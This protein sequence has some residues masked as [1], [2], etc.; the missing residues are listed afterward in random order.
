MHARVKYPNMDLEESNLEKLSNIPAFAKPAAVAEFLAFALV[1]DPTAVYTTIAYWV[2]QP[3]TSGYHA[4]DD[5]DIRRTETLLQK[6][7]ANDVDIVDHESEIVLGSDNAYRTSSM[8][9]GLAHVPVVESTAQS[10][11]DV[12]ASRLLKASISDLEPSASDTASS[13]KLNT[14]TYN[15]SSSL[16]SADCFA[17]I[18]G[19]NKRFSFSIKQIVEE[20][21]P[22]YVSEIV[23]HVYDICQGPTRLDVKVL[24]SHYIDPVTS[25]KANARNSETV[26]MQLWSQTHLSLPQHVFM[27]M[28]W[29][30][31]AIQAARV[32][33]QAMWSQSQSFASNSKSIF[34]ATDFKFQHYFETYYNKEVWLGLYLQFYFSL[35]GHAANPEQY[36]M[37]RTMCMQVASLIACHYGYSTPLSVE[38]NTFFVSRHH[39]LPKEFARKDNFVASGGMHQLLHTIDWDGYFPYQLLDK[40]YYDDEGTDDLNVPIDAKKMEVFFQREREELSNADTFN[41]CTSRIKW[42]ADNMKDHILQWCTWH[43]Q[44]LYRKTTSAQ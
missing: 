42:A 19:H 7:K 41:A 27:N 43:I 35:W 44:E 1:A 31:S 11:I 9:R 17:Y 22:Y 39:V 33:S 12:L 28:P 32:Q 15:L 37:Y 14:R 34:E 30:K 25:R 10:L 38:Q 23:F 4:L 6:I 16:A 8:A 36:L 26:F 18:L 13:I 20:I 40:R 24:P 29:V 3:R 2:T 21:E 5:D